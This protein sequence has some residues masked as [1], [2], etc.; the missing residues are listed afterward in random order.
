MAFGMIDLSQSALRGFPVPEVDIATGSIHRFDDD[1]E[2]NFRIA[3]PHKS[4]HRAGSQ[5]FHR[6]HRIS[7]DAGNLHLSADRIASQT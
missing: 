5:T 3:F 1:I 2:R 4:A 7:F 6:A